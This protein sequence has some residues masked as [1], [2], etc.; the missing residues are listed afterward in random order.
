MGGIISKFRT[1]KNI[2]FETFSKL[3]NDGVIPISDY[4]SAIW[5]YKNSGHAETIQNRACRYFLGLNAKTP[6]SALHWHMG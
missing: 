2:G 1:F 6:I 5:G 3:C 4:A